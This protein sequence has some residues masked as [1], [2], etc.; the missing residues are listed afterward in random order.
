MKSL[1]QAIGAALAIGIASTAAH[2]G[3]VPIGTTTTPTGGALYLDIFSTA[4][5]TPYTE[6]VNLN[7]SLTS[8]LP[9]TGALTPDSA[10]GNFTVTAD[11]SGGAGSV[12]QIDYGVIPGFTSTFTNLGTT[13]YMVL[14]A[15]S[16]TSAS[17]TVSPS[18]AAVVTANGYSA[19]ALSATGIAANWNIDGTLTGP[20]YAIDTTGGK[21]WSA[22]ATQFGALGVAGSDFSASVGSAIGFYNIAGSGRTFKSSQYANATG[23]GFWFLS[24]S[25][26]LTYNV[27][28]ASVAPVPLPAAAWLLISGIAGLGAVGRRRRQAAA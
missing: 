8:I 17:L 3:S 23:V 21:T 2:A 15:Q 25:G 1:T 16:G 6:L 5:A 11:P 10:T 4:T 19:A 24:T 13:G 18:T 28:T 7:A 26:D 27:P 12:L 20:G 22:S 14:A 9:A